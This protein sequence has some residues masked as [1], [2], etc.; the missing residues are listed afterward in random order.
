MCERELVTEQNCNILTLTQLAITAFLSRSPGLLNWGPTLLG[1][2]F[3]YRNLSPTG[4]VSK[5]TDF[6]SSPSYIIVQRPLLLVGVTNCTHSAHPWSRL[7]SAIPQPDVPVIYIGAFLI[8]TAWLG[9]RSIY[10]I[11]GSRLGSVVV[12]CYFLCTFVQIAFTSFLK[13][14]WSRSIEHPDLSSSHQNKTLETSFRFR[15]Q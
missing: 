10:N 6:L 11:N 12:K 13:T 7:H 2:A 14:S 1:A 8:L 15:S 4:L 3:L 9:R 5:L